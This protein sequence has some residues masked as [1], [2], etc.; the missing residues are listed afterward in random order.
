M[1]LASFV[2]GCVVAAPCAGAAVTRQAAG[3][4]NDPARVA[5]THVSLSLAVPAVKPGEVT[6]ITAL[7]K[8]RVAGR[9]VFLRRQRNGRFVNLKYALT[10]RK[11]IAVFR[12]SFRTKGK[13][14]LRAS[15]RA[16]A[17]V[18]AATSV[19][20]IENVDT[21]LPFVLA[22]NM[23]LVEGASGSEVLLLQQR[24]ERSRLLAR[25]TRRALR[26]R[27]STSGLCARESGRSRSQRNRQLAARRGVERWDCP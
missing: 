8:P 20:A 25:D 17:G 21:E 1:W 4:P 16:A 24:S 2:V 19:P 13:V 27:D 23:T 18:R 5:A 9:V 10:N 12:C 14:F 22:P 26:R 11:G 15:V 6:T 7:V 3:Q